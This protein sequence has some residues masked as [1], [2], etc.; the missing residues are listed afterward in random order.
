MR[1]APGST[2][3]PPASA[4]KDKHGF[5][6]APALRSSDNT[7]TD[8]IV[9]LATH[10]ACDRAFCHRWRALVLAGDSHQKIYQ[11]PEFFQYLLET[12][13]SKERVALLTL[14]RRSDGVVVG[15]IPVRIA[16]EEILF[17]IGKLVLFKTSIEMINLLGS[18]P[19]APGGPAMT[20][21]L[22][23]QLLAAFPKAKAIIML[24][25]QLDC[26]HW[27]DLNN[28]VHG[29]PPL[30]SALLG[31][32]RTCHTLPLPA[33]FE[34]YLSK[35]TA[36]KRYNLQRQIRQLG[37]Q[38]G[39]LA[40]ERITAPGE[41]AQLMSAVV[42]LVPTAQLASV[43]PAASFEAL[44][45]SN[46]L[47]CYVLRAGDEVL[48]TIIGTCSPDVWHIHNIFV[49][50][51]YFSLSVGTTAVHLAIKDVMTERCFEKVDFGYG[52]PNHDFRSSHVLETR[53]QV[54]LFD[55]TR[56]VRW[57]FHA[58]ALFTALVEAAIVRI[59][60]LRKSLRTALRANSA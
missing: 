23:L 18:V 39:P 53:A 1:I 40:L 58:H 47:L 42:A 41:V 57:L 10:R 35:F 19:A 6:A 14:S 7:P 38:A 36:K 49:I 51:K 50:K 17:G 46:L 55:R 8:F 29:A 33:S 24:S 45:R 54:L 37:E 31:T 32:W 26:E 2:V 48:A 59:K 3:D 21:Y 27:R 4:F 52:T 34:Q 43:M 13:D 56:P 5:S 9:E 20:Q 16:R 30:A 60:A 28:S 25:L 44:A 12:C 22:G 11:T 15:I